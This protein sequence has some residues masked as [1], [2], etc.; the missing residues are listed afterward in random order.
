M[1]N[2]IQALNLKFTE[3]LCVAAVR[4]RALRQQKSRVLAAFPKCSGEQK[5]PKTCENGPLS[6]SAAQEFRGEILGFKEKVCVRGLVSV[7]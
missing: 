7:V 6:F 1:H 5:S 3:Q 4:A 2:S